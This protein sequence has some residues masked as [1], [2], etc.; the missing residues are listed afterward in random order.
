LVTSLSKKRSRPGSQ[1]AYRPV[2]HLLEHKSSQSV[3]AFK[4]KKR[5][6]D[7][8]EGQKEKY[9]RMAGSKL[10]VQL[11]VNCL[12]IHEQPDDCSVIQTVM[13]SLGSIGAA[14]VRC[15][16]LVERARRMRF[17]NHLT[18][19][20]NN[21][22]VSGDLIQENKLDTRKKKKQQT[23]LQIRHR[24]IDL[25][26]HKRF[27]R[28]VQLNFMRGCIHGSVSVSNNRLRGGRSVSCLSRRLLG[29]G[30]GCGGTSCSCSCSCS[31][32]SGGGLGSHAHRIHRGGVLGNERID[33]VLFSLSALVELLVLLPLGLNPS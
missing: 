30:C 17:E 3:T 10:N 2:E 33:Q 16:V 22:V 19:I 18:G 21:V 12:R 20:C 28:L 4:K 31:C 9:L 14:S 6:E 11:L 26:N 5:S 23:N 25:L 27:D 24:S 1:S 29:G 13:L 32:C 15:T 8:K 7:H